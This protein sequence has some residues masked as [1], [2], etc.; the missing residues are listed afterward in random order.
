[1]DED[2]GGGDDREGIVSPAE[3]AYPARYSELRCQSQQPIAL[4]T[5]TDDVELEI[6]GQQ[7]ERPE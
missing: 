3:Q 6:G 4:R 2:V 7:G 5:L 1:M